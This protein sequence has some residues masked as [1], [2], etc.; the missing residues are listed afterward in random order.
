MLPTHIFIYLVRPR[1][2]ARPDGP[3]LYVETQPPQN[4]QAAMDS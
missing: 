2:A 4:V 3:C 1:L